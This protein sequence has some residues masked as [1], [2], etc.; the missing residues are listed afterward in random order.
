LVLFFGALW[1]IALPEEFFF[2]GLLQR[3]IGEWTGSRYLGLATASLL[4][5]AAHLP[6]REFPNWRLATVAAVAGCFYG[7]AYQKADSIRASMVTHALVVTIW[8]TLFA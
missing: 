2:R 1:V 7:L 5:G 6:F 3:W 8:R 4:F